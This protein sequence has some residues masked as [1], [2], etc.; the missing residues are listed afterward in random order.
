LAYFKEGKIL[1]LEVV[2]V[3]L[4]I[5]AANFA[6][7]TTYLITIRAKLDAL[8]GERRRRLDDEFLSKLKKSV[9]DKDVK[10]DSF[11]SSFKEYNEIEDWKQRV[12]SVPFYIVLA[13]LF[14]LG[15]LVVRLLVVIS[16]VPLFSF[17]VVFII[18]G[19]FVTLYV[20]VTT[21]LIDSDMR[22][23]KQITSAS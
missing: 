5:L 12:F 20:V 18:L 9:K 8:I 22:K 23:W 2:Y 17:D 7:L 15:G 21:C 13:L 11:L 10:I 6:F 3:G 14:T 1:S 4:G 16:S 19:V